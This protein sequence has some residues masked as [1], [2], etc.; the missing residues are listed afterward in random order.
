M[1]AA[2]R[3]PPLRFQ[4]VYVNMA[5]LADIGDDAADIVSILQHSV[6]HFQVTKGNFVT[7]WHGVERLEA[8]GLICFHDPT[9]DLFAGLDVFDNHDA[10]AI[11]FVVHDEISGHETVPPEVGV[12]TM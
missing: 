1:N 3:L 9:G 7:E 12:E 4:I 8:N 2:P 11:G 10:N 5:A 6:A